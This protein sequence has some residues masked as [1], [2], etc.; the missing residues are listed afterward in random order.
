V[1]CAASY[2]A[3]WFRSVVVHEIGHTLGLGHS[4]GQAQS[5]HSESGT[6]DLDAA[7]MRQYL[8]LPSPPADPQPDDIA[9]IRHLYPGAAPPPPPPPPGGAPAT[10]GPGTGRVCPPDQAPKLVPARG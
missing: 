4:T 6:G 7:V 8:S 5:N 9:G 3:S 2:E 1:D 10:C